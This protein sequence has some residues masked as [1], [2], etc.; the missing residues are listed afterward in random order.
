[1]RL[2]MS[3]QRRFSRAKVSAIA[4]AII[5]LVAAG[6]Y[7]WTLLSPKPQSLYGGTIA[8]S[9]PSERETLDPTF[10]TVS[11]LQ[12]IWYSMFE[13]LVVL[14]LNNDITPHLA[15]SYEQLND[16][17]YVF[18]LRQGVKF[19]DDTDFTASAVKFTFERYMTTERSTRTLLAAYISKVEEIDTY[20]VR[21]ML[22]APNAD[23]L[24]IIAGADG[25]IIS[26]SGVQKFGKDFGR[27]PVGTGPFQFVE[28]VAGDHITLKA[29]EGY[30]GGR[31]YLDQ[32]VFKFV[33][34]PSVR[35]L[36]LE[37]GETDISP[38]L[39]DDAKRISEAGSLKVYN[40]P[41]QTY[42]F[43]FFNLTAGPLSNKFVRQALNYAIDRQL[44]VD[45]IYQGYGTPAIGPIA[46]ALRAYYNP[47]LSVYGP[48]SDLEKAK[49]LLAEAGYPNGFKLKLIAPSLIGTV[50]KVQ[51]LAVVLKEQ[52]AR[53][54][55]DVDLQILELGAFNSAVFNRRYESALA[56]WAG[57]GP[58]PTG[59]LFGWYH[60][61]QAF[62]IG[63]FNLQNIVNERMDN[64]LDQL[65]AERDLAKRK[66]L[67]D[68]IQKLIL[69]E[70]YDVFIHHPHRIYAVTQ[71][72]EGFA[73]HPSWTYDFVLSL[74]TIGVD[75]RLKPSGSAKF[76]KE[77][78]GDGEITAYLSRE[79]SKKLSHCVG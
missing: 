6:Y 20:T 55:V 65:T 51:D 33:A 3:K 14:D 42:S 59:V 53:I 9:L 36:Q 16:V 76:S 69:D 75:V 37:R 72:V 57:S 52:W 79:F 39:P 73:L 17:T 10:S 54:G 7:G 32:V 19:H 30:W 40:N 11:F 66:A 29:F 31:P 41:E 5:I 64:L 58:Y 78:T 1:M 38:I 74:K 18:H 34:D 71:R 12:T 44:I 77:T 47:S 26:P 63:R 35:V 27:N 62:K 61:S 13:P 45:T 48:K 49:Q 46:P 68:D 2:F 4:L 70:A 67:V 43:V 15:E 21:I 25:L 50:P 24:Y 28:W 23:F 8:V 60:S 56:A 22:K